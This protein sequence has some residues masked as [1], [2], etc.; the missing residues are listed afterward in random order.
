MP[1]KINGPHILQVIFHKYVFSQPWVYWAVSCSELVHANSDKDLKRDV[2]HSQLRT[3]LC[4]LKSTKKK[5]G[6]LPFYKKEEAQLGWLAEHTVD[7]PISYKQYLIDKFYSFH[8]FLICPLNGKV[9]L[10]SVNSFTQL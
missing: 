5:V 7:Y 6:M 8:Y 9:F 4:A 1:K 10:S 2:L 3:H